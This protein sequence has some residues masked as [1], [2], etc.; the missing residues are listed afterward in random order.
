MRGSEVM[1]GLETTYEAKDDRGFAH[2]GFAW[3]VGP[4]SKRERGGDDPVA[5]V[6]R[7]TRKSDLPRRTSLTWTDL[8]A[9]PDAASAIGRFV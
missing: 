5:R 3:V 8:S 9:G 7:G 4:V 2:S 6:L 1:R